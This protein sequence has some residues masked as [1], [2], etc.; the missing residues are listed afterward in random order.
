MLLLIINCIV[1]FDLRWDPSSQS[2]DIDNCTLNFNSLFES[3][4]LRKA[5]QVS[6][7]GAW[8]DTGRPKKV[9]HEITIFVKI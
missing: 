1:T 2:E 4:N 9:P 5:V 6:E 3:G 7:Y 8:R